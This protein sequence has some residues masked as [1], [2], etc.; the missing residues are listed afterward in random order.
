MSLLSLL[1][2][3]VV[4]DPDVVD[5][6][7]ALCVPCIEGEG[8]PSSSDEG[9]GRPS[10]SGEG[11]PQPHFS[12]V[13]S[14]LVD[15]GLM[16]QLPGQQREAPAGSLPSAGRWALEAARRAAAF[17][18][19]WP[20]LCIDATAS[21]VNRCLR[22]LQGEADQDGLLA[23]AVEG[24]TLQ[25]E[26]PR[27]PSAPFCACPL[28][29]KAGS[30]TLAPYIELLAGLAGGK[31]RRR[32]P[33]S[34]VGFGLS[35]SSCTNSSLGPASNARSV[36]SR[37]GSLVG[38]GLLGL[39]CSLEQAPSRDWRTG[40]LSMLLLASSQRPAPGTQHH[41]SFLPAV[42]GLAVTSMVEQ[43]ASLAEAIHLCWGLLAVQLAAPGG[44]AACLS[45]SMGL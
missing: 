37:P 25:P 26:A 31:L 14:F 13:E 3:L 42:L 11:G 9:E 32:A 44:V 27:G 7:A 40:S 36:S 17:L 39:A 2:L 24:L 19:A 35:S 28:E 33:R 15:L 12:E 45:R 8:R 22:E 4:D 41:A 6:L 43:G 23:R 20:G 38:G 21:M 1:Q 5:E 16:L 30:H 34:S 18:H 10:S 29:V